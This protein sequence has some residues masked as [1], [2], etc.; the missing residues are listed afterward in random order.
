M[1]LGE[2]SP[3]SHTSKCLHSEK[4]KSLYSPIIPCGQPNSKV[5]T[6]SSVVPGLQVYIF[7]VFVE[8]LKITF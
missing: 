1:V 6:L 7:H 8:Q 5:P 2:D 3:K 4:I